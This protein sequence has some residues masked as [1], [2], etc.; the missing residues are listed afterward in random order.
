[1]NSPNHPEQS[2]LP[3]SAYDVFNPLDLYEEGPGMAPDA[4]QRLDHVRHRL[5]TAYDRL[6][7]SATQV[8]L[9]PQG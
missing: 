5:G 8:S 9:R 6:V 1:M 4:I 3:A 2:G 7:L